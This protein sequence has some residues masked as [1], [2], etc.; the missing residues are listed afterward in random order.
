MMVAKTG[1]EKKYV[2]V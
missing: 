2:I 1:E